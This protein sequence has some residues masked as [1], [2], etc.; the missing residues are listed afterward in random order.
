[1][2]ETS[3]LYRFSNSNHCWN[4]GARYFVE[5]NI[6]QI[7]CSN[8]DAINVLFNAEADCRSNPEHPGIYRWNNS[9]VKITTFVI[10]MSWRTSILTTYACVYLKSIS[11]IK[12]ML[13]GSIYSSNK[14]LRCD[15][16]FFWISSCVLIRKL[17]KL[18]CEI[19]MRLI[20]LSSAKH[21]MSGYVTKSIRL[22][23]IQWDTRLVITCSY[24]DVKKEIYNN[25]RL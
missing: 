8:S 15:Y 13:F 3:S 4:C 20:S 9:Y 25:E 19:G 10:I 6:V 1:M 24:S 23:I 5:N 14:Q 22:K 18:P 16:V 21:V 7:L 12:L 2:Y 11:A 17:Y